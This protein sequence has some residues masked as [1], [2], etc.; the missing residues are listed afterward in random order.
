MKSGPF[1]EDLFDGYERRLKKI[2]KILK[3]DINFEWL[4]IDSNYVKVHQHTA[5]ARGENRGYINSMRKHI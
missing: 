5:R 4:I 1:I 2:F 3:C